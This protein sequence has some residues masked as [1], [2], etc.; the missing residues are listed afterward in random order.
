VVQSRSKVRLLGLTATPTPSGAAAWQR[1][2]QRFPQTLITVDPAELVTR[3]ILARPVF[4]KVDTHISIE[5]SAA[6]VR[7]S[8]QVDVPD[9][10]LKEL[11]KPAR[12]QILVEQW[13]SNRKLWGKTLIFATSIQHADA[14][15]RN[16]A[17]VGAPVRSIHSRSPE[18]RSETLGWFRASSD[19]AVLV[20]VGMLT[21]GVDLPDA[22]TAFLARPTTSPVLMRQMVGRV[23]RGPKAKGT[24]LAHLVTF[25][26]D[27][28][29]F[30]G[31]IEPVDLRNLPEG[32]STAFPD[33]SADSFALITSVG[34]DLPASW[35]WCRGC[36]PT[37]QLSRRKARTSRMRSWSATTSCPRR[38]FLCFV[39]SK[40]A[41]LR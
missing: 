2:R 40:T 17:K 33:A 35:R 15:K 7:R 19:D 41:S 3:G 6:D 13:V 20:S 38:G 23:L 37:T 29:N 32:G 18:A 10:V 12:D 21:E 34:Q 8:L 31:V 9:V 24:S 25:H 16:L 5:M 28:V 27:W 1:F 4:H 39:I 22:Q 11:A 26:D 36:M 30:T 14:L